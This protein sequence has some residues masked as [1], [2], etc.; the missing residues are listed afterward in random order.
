M[1]NFGKK[2]LRVEWKD[3]PSNFTSSKQKEIEKAAQKK[4]DAQ[5]VT[6]VP[7]ALSNKS[8]SE[9]SE[10]KADLTE[11]ISDTNYQRKLMDKFV[12]DNGYSVNWELLT[13][14]DD[15]VNKE[16][17][18]NKDAYSK[19]DEIN[20][21]K[22]TLTNFLSFSDKTQEIDFS[23]FKGITT[24][25]SEPEN[26]AGKTILIIDS[27]LF[28]FFGDTTRTVTNDEIFNLYT[29]ANEVN[30]S[31]EVE[32]NGVIY[33][34]ERSLH[35]SYKKKGKHKGESEI[36][37][38]LDFAYFDETGTKVSL[39]S[40]SPQA[41]TANI[42]EKVGN[43]DDFL[44]TIITTANNLEDLIDSKPTE[45][46]K[47]FTRFIGLELFKE[48][49]DIAKKKLNEWK[50]QTKLYTYNIE[51]LKKENENKK[52]QIEQL[53]EELKVKR[54]ELS[55]ID[56]KYKQAET[57]KENYFQEKHFIDEDL[58]SL[59]K[60][61]IVKNI[62]KLKNDINGFQNEI[63][64]INEKLKEPET[65]FDEDYYN[66]LES[67]KNDLIN[68]YYELSNTIKQKKEKVQ[69]LK[70][71]EYCPTCKQP[72]KDVD[73]SQEIEQL[74]S[75]LSEK[76]KELNNVESDLNSKKKELNNLYQLKKEWDEYEKN[77]MTKQKKEVELEKCQNNLQKGEDKLQRFEEN[78]NKIKENK[79]I[80]QKVTE[81]NA[82]LEDLSKQYQSVNLEIN[83]KQNDIDQKTNEI[84]KNEEIIKEINKE[85]KID[86]T[87][88]VYLEMFGKKGISKMVLGSMIPTINS[89]LNQFL[90]DCANFNLKISL[91]DKD[92]V[93]F[94]MEDIYNDQIKPLRMGSGYEKTVSALAL[95]CVLSK[96][97]ALP[98]PN[99]IVFDEPF[100]KVG[101]KENLYKL[102]NLFQQINNYFSNIFILTHNPIVQNWANNEL[103]IKKE[104]D[105]SYI[106]T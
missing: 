58:L 79:E 86:K 83:S 106:D 70:N 76:E 95:R 3:V 29:N 15:N 35:R 20:I 77:K 37:Q 50:P 53:N 60:D 10:V 67:G 17:V 100:G 32:I 54:E 13:K 92:E 26:F 90:I 23:E 65:E 94:W 80:D 8:E 61:Y 105:I 45:R 82:K 36:T 84:S 43:R 74:N 52:L 24:I 6:V 14:L 81:A 34:I 73:H 27:L 57:D 56:E 62:E 55:N 101:Q 42:K 16:L 51:E 104:N 85:K 19:H 47:I 78:Q 39:N 21:K 9:T 103:I 48:K 18:E 5:N 46:G 28:L 96:I 75:E 30:V 40:K 59:D 41:T 4:Y 99:I 25:L 66:D 89:Y 1:S 49:E 33:Y 64:N 102:E 98:K 87:F 88:Q 2:Y 11:E 91:N 63:A 69:E 93:E 44:I 72:L 71:S 97:C 68:K 38:K 12:K 31:G 22:I 7:V